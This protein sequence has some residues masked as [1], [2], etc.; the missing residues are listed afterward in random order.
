MTH[1]AVYGIGQGLN[2]RDAA[3][4]ATQKAIDQLGALRPSLAIALISEEYDIAEV[5][6]GLAGLLGDTPLWGFS[7]VRLL[8]ENGEQQ[9]AVAVALISASD[10]KAQVHWWPNF[11]ADGQETARQV[12]RTLRSELVLPQAVL[13]AADGVNGSLVPLCAALTDLPSVI[14]GCLASGGYTSGRTYLLA[15]N[16]SGH[17]GLASAALGG[18]LRLGSGVAHGWRDSGLV[19]NV[20]RS[21]DV[22][23]QSIDDAPAAELYARHFGRSAR[24]WA[25]PPL[26]DMARLYPFGVEDYTGSAELLLR[27]PLRVEV[28][29]SLRMSA[30]VPEGSTA[31]LMLG[32]PQ[33][34]LKAVENAA[35]QALRGLDSARS[36]VALAFVDLAWLQLFGTQAHQVPEAIQ[37]ALGSIPMIGAYTLGQVAR[38]AYA[39]TPQIYN[40]SI[41]I[42]IIGYQE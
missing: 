20:T 37:E 19:F 17:S 18:R 10:V 38:P 35:A 9:R 6:A 39:A 27:S 36:L 28:D 3:M 41:Q 33:A 7:T 22:W 26:T 21:R 12:V 31:H 11:A 24:E 25:F 15:R 29:G 1:L 5:S 4:Q 34:C 40:Q 23:V 14:T 42:L 2:G 16:Q 32:D 8:A 13:L 30:A